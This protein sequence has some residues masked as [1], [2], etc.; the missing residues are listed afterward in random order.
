ML[1][2][3]LYFYIGCKN[4]LHYGT[5]VVLLFLIKLVKI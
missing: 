4:I 5:K 3:P 1:L 2:Q